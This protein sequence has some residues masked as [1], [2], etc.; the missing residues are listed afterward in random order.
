MNLKEVQNTYFDYQDE[1][2][3]YIQEVQEF[4][5]QKQ[6]NPYI[7]IDEKHQ[8]HIKIKIQRG[9]QP[10]D[11]FIQQ[12]EETLMEFVEKNCLEEIWTMITTDINPLLPE[13]TRVQTSMEFIYRGC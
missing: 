4:F 8:L 7:W 11:E 2:T 3:N 1:K 5:L 12:L 9:T 13:E 6:I 10:T